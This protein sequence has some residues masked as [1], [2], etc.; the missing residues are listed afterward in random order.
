MINLLLLGNFYAV[1]YRWIQKE[2]DE[3]LCTT[4]SLVMVR[5]QLPAQIAIFYVR[6]SRRNSFKN[7]IRQRLYDFLRFLSFLFFSFFSFFFFVCFSFNSNNNCNS[8]NCFTIPHVNSI[9]KV[10]IAFTFRENFKKSYEF[11]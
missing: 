3:L 8:Y 2:S 4:W 1:T 9:L 7:D 5:N 6:T 10:Y 11:V